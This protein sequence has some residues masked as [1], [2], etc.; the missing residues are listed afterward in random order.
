MCVVLTYGMAAHFT[1]KQPQLP[2]PQPPFKSGIKEEKHMLAVF[3][4]V[5]AT[6]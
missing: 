4:S 5:H 3:K 6:K 1:A 2:R